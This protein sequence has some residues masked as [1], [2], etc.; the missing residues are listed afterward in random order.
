MGKGCLEAGGEVGAEGGARAVWV[1]QI[2]VIIL[3]LT[4]VILP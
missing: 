2:A 4:S 1:A 3:K